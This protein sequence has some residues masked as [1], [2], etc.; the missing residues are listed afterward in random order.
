MTE[1]KK[2]HTMG[3]RKGSAITRAPSKCQKLKAQRPNPHHR[4]PI[5]VEVSSDDDQSFE[6][7]DSVSALPLIQQVHSVESPAEA[8]SDE[9]E[10]QQ[11]EVE[12]DDD[13]IEVTGSEDKEMDEACDSH[14]PASATSSSDAEADQISQVDDN[15]QDS[16]VEDEESS[17]SDLEPGA[18]VLDL[19]SGASDSGLDSLMEDESD[20]NEAEAGMGVIS[21]AEQRGDLS[22]EEGGDMDESEAVLL[23]AIASGTLSDKEMFDVLPHDREVLKDLI[24]TLIA[25]VKKGA[26]EEDRR[27]F[28]RKELVN[29][30]M[31]VCCKYYGYNKE[32][33][34]YFFQLLG[35]EKSVSFMEANETRRPMT[36]RT[37]VLKTRRRDLARTLI[38]RGANVD[39]IGDWCKEGLVV[40][41]STVPIGATPEYLAG[42]YMLQ[43]ASSFLPVLALD[44]QPDERVVD[45]AAAPGGKTTFIAQKMR[46]TGVIFAN[47]HNKM[48]SF[49]LTANIHRMG[50]RN[51]VVTNFDGRKAPKYIGKVD[52]V[53]LDAPCTGSG[54]IAKDPSIKTKRSPEDFEKQAGMQRELLAAAIEMVDEKSVKGGIIV[55]STCSVSV[56]ENEAVVNALLKTKKV[57]LVDTGLTVGTPGLTQHKHMQFHPTMKLTRRIYPHINNMDGFFVAK[58]KKV[59]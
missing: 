26:Q 17:D 22:D 25:G 9:V 39:P 20:D 7:A 35:P 27:G 29:Q 42:H 45:M 2:T 18:N 56:E 36:L 37:N 11:K 5:P 55:Y 15:D 1:P 51:C 6:T 46:N 12:S 14:D 48:R 10:S 47:D 59:C 3:K 49:A 8:T 31:A 41:E 30:L 40:K 28:A 19:D 52:R 4:K 13:P 50:V 16:S 23:K 44:P 43:S 57:K 24:G 58:L 54:V 32:L 34:K 53:L 21:R 38:S 33:V